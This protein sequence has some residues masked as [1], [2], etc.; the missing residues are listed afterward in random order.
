M[1]A[2]DR[3]RGEIV[4]Q[5][6]RAGS[7]CAAIA[8]EIR[9]IRGLI[10]QLAAVLVADARFVADYLD[11]FQAFDLMAQYAD[12]SAN[13]LDRLAA[14]QSADDAIAGVRLTVIQDR[15]RAAVAGE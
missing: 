12:E 10:E 3:H 6:D 5:T 2:E 4:E 7:L 1:A 13:L 8:A 11:Q 9:E 15:L 14:G